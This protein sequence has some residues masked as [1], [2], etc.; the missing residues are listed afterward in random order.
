MTKA[1][2][3]A[4]LEG[5]LTEVRAIAGE[6]RRAAGPA[7]EAA[8]HWRLQALVETES[9]WFGAIGPDAQAAFH[10]AADRAIALAVAEVE[11]RL[12]DDELWLDPLTAPGLGPAYETGWNSELPE[13]LIG[14]FR[15]FSSKDTGPPLGELD[16][17]G[18][19]IW[20]VFLSAAKLLDP[21]LEEFG[22]PPSEIPNL[23]GGNYGLAPRTAPQLDP[24]G[25]LSR[26]WGRYRLAYER[27]RALKPNR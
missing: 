3:R 18:N 16:D 19:R 2:D 10:E 6:F 1:D 11:R 13:W 14:I 25:T 12:S 8:L 4:A 5:A 15:R 17:P 24:S 26:L 22:L 7:T 23:G 20:L 27:Y 21:V 9:D